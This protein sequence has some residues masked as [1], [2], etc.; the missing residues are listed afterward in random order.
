M[1]KQSEVFY[2][3]EGELT[4]IQG[5]IDF[6]ILLSSRRRVAA[7]SLSIGAAQSGQG[8]RDGAAASGGA[9]LGLAIARAIVEGHDGEIDV[10]DRDDAP[11]GARFTILLPAAE[12]LTN[13]RIIATRRS[14]GCVSRITSL[15]ARVVTVGNV[16]EQFVSF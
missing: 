6:R 9:G 10:Q 1:G 3:R 13:S 7:G 12:R 8:P 4:L 15:S 14:R 11:S 2:N 5:N 16:S